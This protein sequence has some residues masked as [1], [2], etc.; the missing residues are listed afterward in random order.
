[1]DALKAFFKKKKVDKKFRNAGTG[2]SLITP[3]QGGPS[4]DQV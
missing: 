2:H 1:M 4:N 3:R